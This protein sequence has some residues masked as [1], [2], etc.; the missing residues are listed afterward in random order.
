[1]GKLMNKIITIAAANLLILG[2]LATQNTSFAQ[3]TC[4]T[5]TYKL[6]VNVSEERPTKV[7]LNGKDADTIEVC[8]GDQV[9]WQLVG[10]GRRFYIDF[11]NGAPFGGDAKQNS[12]NGKVL[13]TIGDSAEVGQSYKYDVGVE[14][15]G[16]L[17]PHIRIRE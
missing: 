3:D 10:S 7:T 15:G 13:V 12:A 2:M 11:V 17:D 6:K 5:D 8:I 1:M 14:D 4:G 16:V 9:E